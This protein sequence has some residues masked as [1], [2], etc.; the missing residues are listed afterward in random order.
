M[1]EKIQD[2]KPCLVE[3]PQ[4]FSVFYR[5]KYLY[6][7]YAPQKAVCQT[8]QNLTVLP[9]TLF[10]C[11]SPLLSY[12]LS[13]LLEKL[14]DSSFCLFCEFDSALSDFSKAQ[15]SLNDKKMMKAARLNLPELQSLPV[16]LNQ[17]SYTTMEGVQ[18]LP[19]GSF[20]RVVRIDFSAGVQFHKELYDQL[21]SACSR[22]IMTFWAN[23]MT[24]VKFGRKYSQNFFKNLKLL[25]ATTPIQSFFHS[26]TKP[27][28]V[29]GAG[30]STNEGI[31]LIK[32]AVPS[33]YC[34]LCADT[35]LQPLLASGIAVDG[36]FIEEAQAIIKKAFIGTQ[37]NSTKIFAGM[38][39]LSNLSKITKTQNISFFT[40]KYAKA[41]FL[42]NLLDKGI[43]PPANEPF[44]S[45]GLTAVYYALKFREDS[46]VPVFVYGLDF[47]YSAGLT[48]AK[49]TMAQKQRLITQ[50][51]LNPPS[52]YSAAFNPLAEKVPSKDGRTFY[53]TRT[54]KNYAELFNGLFCD[55]E[56]LFDAAS[57]GI[58]LDIIRKKPSDEPS[59]AESSTAS[60]ADGRAQPFIPN[61]F[62][63]C[64]KESIKD[65]MLKEKEALEKLRDV[66]TGKEKLSSEEQKEYIIKEASSREYLFLHFPDGI[67]FKYE[68]SF[69]KRIRTEID[70]FLKFF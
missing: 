27:I 15:Y 56:N 37:K 57:T 47:S 61:T 44:G 28:I 21:S 70:F 25:P 54:L 64:Q 24:L 59:Q 51:R 46:S 36:V 45:V 10:L 17:P 9:G 58:K 48:H 62:S 63:D 33:S 65:F 31:R 12:G 49:G 52:A 42:D 1:T 43:I 38:S 67:T 66:L 3:T 6:S 40:T 41:S 68:T 32:N 7:K 50:T 19:A 5:N 16:I 11:C 39:A 55:E 22:A 2:E 29:F 14:D 69:L 26:V 53:T 60:Q 8:I 13:E 4:G 23:R 20:K 18:L 35:A 30:E 34:I